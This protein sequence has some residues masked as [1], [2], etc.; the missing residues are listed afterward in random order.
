M[1]EMGKI[2]YEA[3]GK[4]RG[5]NTPTWEMLSPVERAHWDAAAQAVA[6]ALHEPSPPGGIQIR[7]GDGN[8]QVNSW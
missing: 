8:S 2:A 6:R 3:Y 1:P 4:S 7:I 5:W